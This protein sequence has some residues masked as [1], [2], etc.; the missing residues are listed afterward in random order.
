M[1]RALGRYHP[2]FVAIA[3]LL[4]LLSS[5]VIPARARGAGGQSSA[6]LLLTTYYKIINDGQKS[7]NFSALAS[8]LTPDT[9]L[10]LS[11]PLGKTEVYRGLKA[12]IAYNHEIYLRVPG[13]YFKPVI[14][15]DISPTVLF[16]YDIAENPRHTVVGKCAHLFIIRN[17]RF[18]SHDYIT[19][20][21]GQ[22]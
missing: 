18:S 15:R 10:T 20:Y 6:D 14:V 17:G 7:G 13:Y 5:A 11:N 9:V 19:Y 1:S 12:V 2:V 22:G 8:V 21:T 3:C 4:L 16:T